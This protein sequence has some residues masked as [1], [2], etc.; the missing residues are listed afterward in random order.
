[1]AKAYVTID[2]Y[3][4]TDNG[5]TSWHVSHREHYLDNDQ[6][7]ELEG[8]YAGGPA[9]HV[10]FQNS[11]I[12]LANYSGAGLSLVEGLGTVD[13][14]ADYVTQYLEEGEVVYLESPTEIEGVTWEVCFKGFV[15]DEYA[16]QS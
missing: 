11:G 3:Q 1:M 10:T 2:T 6:D 9:M 4:W 12:L 14:S 8:N 16:S 5:N 13:T 7:V 15:E